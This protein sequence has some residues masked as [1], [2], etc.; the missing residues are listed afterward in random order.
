MAALESKNEGCF[1]G[2]NL[3]AGFAQYNWIGLSLSWMSVRCERDQLP[4]SIFGAPFLGLRPFFAEEKAINALYF[5][6]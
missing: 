6:R 2:L 1:F 5:N 3:F 4:K